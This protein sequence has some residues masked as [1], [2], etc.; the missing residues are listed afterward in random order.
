M[1]WGQHYHLDR[2]LFIW[3][4]TLVLWLMGQEFEAFHDLSP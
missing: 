3:Q 4:T 2:G 1:R